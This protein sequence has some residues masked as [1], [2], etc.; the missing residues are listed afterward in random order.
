[1]GS[2]RPIEGNSYYTAEF[3]VITVIRVAVLEAKVAGLE[4]KV[5]SLVSLIN[6]EFGAAKSR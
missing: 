6:R 5:E 4:S 2:R 1:M 3:I